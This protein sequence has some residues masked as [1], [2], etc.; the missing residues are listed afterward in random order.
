M[1]NIFAFLLF[2]V[3]VEWTV[4]QN[5]IASDAFVGKNTPLSRKNRDFVS[6]QYSEQLRK[7]KIKDMYFDANVG[8]LPKKENASW[9]AQISAGYCFNEQSAV[10]IGVGAW[11]REQVYTRSGLGLGM[12]YRHNY[13]KRLLVK[14]EF[15]YLLQ[16][17]MHDGELDKEM[18]Y[19][20]ELSKPIYF[21]LEA[22]WRVWRYITLGIAATQ[23]GDLYFKRYIDE[24]RTTQDL[25]RLNALTVQLGF[26][27]DKFLI[28]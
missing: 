11:G 22:H 21:K 25:W 16:R 27:F 28:K 18:I 10:G 7:F 24:T 8:Y 1:K 5:G 14:A 19:L 12:Q 20:S 6:Q 15:G 17:K 23:S 4:A 13:P 26:S 9:A 3:F 2:F